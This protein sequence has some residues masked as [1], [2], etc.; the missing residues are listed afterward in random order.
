[1]AFMTFS[2]GA[3]LTASQVN[4][5]LAR[6]AVIVCT[7]TTRPTSPPEGMTIYETDTDKM[8]VYT[9]ATT[10]WVPPW[11]TAWGYVTRVTSTATTSP[12]G[13]ATIDLSG[14][15]TGALT[16]VANRRW[17]VTADVYVTCTSAGSL[18]RVIEGASTVRAENY[19]GT[20][21][22][23]IG[24][25]Q[26]AVGIFTTTAGSITLKAQGLDWFGGTRVYGA[27]GTASLTVE[28]LGPSGT[29]A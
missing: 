22:G 17:K 3:V 14:L 20:T 1:M 13:T 6:Q 24:T 19:V 10:G 4:T 7:S 26:R 2:P 25:S 28:D 29:A 12:S 15:T 16:A 9:T 27:A 18:L 11:N 5:Y 8:L 21:G 23:A